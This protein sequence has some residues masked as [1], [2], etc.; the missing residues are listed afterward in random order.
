[1][2]EQSYP[3]FV[4]YTQRHVVWV[5]ADSPEQAAEQL[6]RWPYDSTDDGETLFESMLSVSAPKRD[7]EWEDIYG[8]GDYSSPFTTEAD[9]HV[10][11]HR[12]EMR[13][14]ELEAQKAACVAAG[15]PDVETYEATGRTWCKGC[16]E[17]LTEA[18]SS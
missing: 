7:W 11:A 6:A 14:R 9:A 3:V 16:R 12:T 10:E 5:E 17:Y 18:V 4:E 8:N 15:H 1:M 2:G 13:R